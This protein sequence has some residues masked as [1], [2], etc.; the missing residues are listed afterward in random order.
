METSLLTEVIQ[1]SA[2]AMTQV[3]KPGI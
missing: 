1:I 2:K 3:R